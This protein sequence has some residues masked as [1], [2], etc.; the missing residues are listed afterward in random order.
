MEKYVKIWEN[1]LW[2]KLKVYYGLFLRG[3]HWTKWRCLPD[4]NIEMMGFHGFSSKTRLIPGGYDHTFGYRVGPMDSKFCP[5][6]SVPTLVEA[7]IVPRY[8]LDSVGTCW[9]YLCVY[10]HVLFHSSV[11]GGYGDGLTVCLRPPIPLATPPPSPLSFE[12]NW[13]APSSNWTC[14]ILLEQI[15]SEVCVHESW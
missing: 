13:V 8:L 4:S 5:C 12:M 6:Y 2:M 15:L 1:H 9:H 14:C 11:Y 3:T 10:P 7:P